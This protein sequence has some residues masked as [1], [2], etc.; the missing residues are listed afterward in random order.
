MAA[1]T[2][3]RF[4]RLRAEDRSHLSPFAYSAQ[5]LGYKYFGGKLDDITC[6][7]AYVLQATQQARAAPKL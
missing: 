4:G 6:V 7:V 3:A 5:Q 2:L 1:A